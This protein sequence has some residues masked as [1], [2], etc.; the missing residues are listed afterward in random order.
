MAS[1][2]LEMKGISKT[3]PGTQALTDVDLQIMPGE[4]HALIGENGAGKSTLMNILM[5]VHKMDQGEIIL[6][7]SMVDIHSP[8]DAMLKGISMVPQELNLIPEVSVCENIF[9][10]NE[11]LS[12]KGGMINWNAAKKTAKELLDKM[13]VNIDVTQKLRHL[14][15]AYQQLVSIAR[16][17]AAGT[18][19]LILD[20]PTAS[21]T[22]NEA[23]LL[24]QAMKQMRDKGNSIIFITHHLEEVKVVTDRVTVMRDSRVVFRGDTK[25][26]SIDEMILHMANRQV[27]KTVNVKRAVG[28][29]VF[30]EVRDFTRKDEFSDISFQIYKGEIFG[31]AGLVG[32]GRTELI[33][34]I[35]GL[36]KKD[37][38]HI[39]ID[40]HEVRIKSPRDIIRYGIGYVPEERRKEGI[41][42]IMSVYE[43]LI[44]PSYKKI[45]KAGLIRFDQAKELTNS[46]IRDL[47]IKT[48]SHSKVIKELSG[49]N[50]QKVIF[51]RWM[52]K[53][54]KML[55]LDEPT[56]GIDIN[57]KTEIHKLIKQ[58]AD[59]GVTVI[60][61]SSE[62]EEVLSVADRIMVMHEGHIKGFVDSPQD[63]VQ[64]D[65]L[66][67]ALQ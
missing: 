41:F 32:A 65:I 38:G 67:I 19:I 43:N 35:Y 57:A 63:L 14:S 60:V 13:G 39:Y 55:I 3:F 56:R 15:P 9:L 29:D 30:L 21:L 6:N 18:Q 66:K 16:S 17:L 45:S 50:Q 28:K 62:I 31:I 1:W 11:K 48:S 4:I 58:M 54:V 23:E 47:A 20:E 26:L 42:P 8:H 33:K 59:Q 64:E 49:G 44:M 27:E 25:D 40:G 5:G 34:A 36:T 61:I 52:A 51:A 37:A 7:G 46:F 24:F 12:K 2:A 10:G 53:G 22:L